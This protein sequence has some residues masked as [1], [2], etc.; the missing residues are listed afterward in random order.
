MAKVLR[1]EIEAELGGEKRTLRLGIGDLEDIED[2]LKVG[3]LELIQMLAQGRYRIG[4]LR[5]IMATALR[6]AGWKGTDDDVRDMIRASGPGECQV[7]CVRLFN[8]ALGNEDKGFDGDE[9]EAGNAPA[10]AVKENPPKESTQKTSRSGAISK[11]AA[12]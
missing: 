6:A 8:V 7:I 3:L 12:A 9:D 10:P 4:H 11:S 5:E 1:G 2:R